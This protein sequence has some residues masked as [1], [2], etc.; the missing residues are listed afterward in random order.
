MYLTRINFMPDDSCWECGL[1]GGTFYQTGRQAVSLPHIIRFKS[2]RF[3]LQS[4]PTTCAHVQVCF[5]CVCVCVCVVVKGFKKLKSSPTGHVGPEGSRRVKAPSF[6][7]NGTVMVVGCQPYAP[8]AFTSRSIPDDRKH[9][10][11]SF[12]L[13]AESTPGP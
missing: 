1:C 2:G 12:L 7:D 3:V 11:Y 8:S 13:E 4:K 10:W 6:R 9:T 5:V